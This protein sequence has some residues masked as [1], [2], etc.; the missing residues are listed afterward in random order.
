MRDTT[1]ILNLGKT[2]YVDRV[3]G[4]QESPARRY[5]IVRLAERKNFGK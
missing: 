1:C 2:K 3:D 5:G 4:S